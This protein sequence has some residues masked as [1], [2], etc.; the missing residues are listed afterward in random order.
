[1]KSNTRDLFNKLINQLTISE[2][3]EEKEAIIRWALEHELNL[4]PTDIM[5]AREISYDAK[6]FEEIILR[7]NLYEPVQY[8]FGETSFFGRS[9]KVNPSVLIPRPET[10]VLIKT[11]KDHFENFRGK[12]T[13][14]DIGTGSG[15]IATTLA[16]EIPESEIYAT[17]ISE[18]ALAVARENAKALKA[19]IT[20]TRH[21]IIKEPISW[22]NLDAVVSN[23]PYVPEQE[24]STL[25]ENVINYEPHLALFSGGDSA[26]IF[27]EV[28]AQKAW[29]ALR[30]GGLLITEINEH[31]GPE[32]GDL[33]LSIGYKQVRIHKDL[34]GRDRIV[35]GIR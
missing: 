30:E 1:M 28:I 13:L 20:F 23:P 5:V 24:R 7:L 18:E 2:P 10:E 19:H 29:R 31:Y 33:F 15:C 14:L 6:R 3:R 8:I 27:Y 32:T 12:V 26:L 11:I 25:R 35:S 17:D 9:F 4:R 21:D 22:Q 34:T 16:L